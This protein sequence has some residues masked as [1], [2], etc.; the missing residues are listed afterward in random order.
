MIPLIW[1]FSFSIYI[2]NGT[3]HGITIDLTN[4]DELSYNIPVNS[5]HTKHVLRL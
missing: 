5:S 1:D 2:P 4:M 3:L